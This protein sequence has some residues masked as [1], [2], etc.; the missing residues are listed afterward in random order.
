MKYRTTI[1]TIAA[2]GLLSLSACEEPGAE[3]DGTDA[4]MGEPMTEE[5]FELEDM[6]P[7]D[8]DPAT[9]AETAPP[10]AD[11]ESTAPA[12]DAMSEDAPDVM[13][14]EEAPE[15]DAMEADAMEPDEEGM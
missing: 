13:A 12:P 14:E 7:V 2:T 4:D 11:A 10:G 8:V 15:G 3:A 1:L 6:P 9:G 5:S